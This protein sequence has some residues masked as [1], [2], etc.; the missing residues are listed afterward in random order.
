MSALPHPIVRSLIACEEIR[1]D[2]S[3]PRR[4][5]LYRIVNSVRAVG[6]PPY[7][8]VRKQFAVFAV[9]TNGRG[10]GKLWLEI[11]HADTD[12]IIYHTPKQAIAF[13]ANPLKLNGISFQM[14][15]LIIPEPGLHWVRLWFEDAI[16]GDLPIN[17]K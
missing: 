9:V 16:I 14:R 12:A 7:P 5:N 6:D 11:R 17:V 3:N 1:P 13:P 4:I 10:R 8:A 15:N 2:R